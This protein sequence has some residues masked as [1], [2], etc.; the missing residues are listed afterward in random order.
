M[1]QFEDSLKTDD[2]WDHTEFVV[3]LGRTIE[4]K[5]HNLKDGEVPTLFTDVGSPTFIA[6]KGYQFIGTSGLDTNYQPHDS[7][8]ENLAI[9]WK[10]TLLTGETTDNF[11][12]GSKSATAT[13]G[14]RVSTTDN[15]VVGYLNATGPVGNLADGI[16]T[17][18]FFVAARLASDSVKAFHKD[19]LLNA[20]T[21]TF[22]D[23]PGT[24]FH[25]GGLDSA[26]VFIEGSFS[27]AEWVWVGD[28]TLLDKLP[29][30][31]NHMLMVDTTFASNTPPSGDITPPTTPG[32]NT[33]VVGATDLSFEIIPLPTDANGVDHIDVEL[34]QI[35]N[36]TIA[37]DATGFTISGLTA[38][39]SYDVRIRAFDVAGNASN[40]SNEITVSTSSGGGGPSLTITIDFET[41]P[42]QPPLKVTGPGTIAERTI[43]DPTDAGNIV[44][45]H[46][47]EITDGT[48]LNTNHSSRR[49][50]E[51]HEGI[52]G[53]PNRYTPWFSESAFRFRIYF[54]TD[55]DGT[56]GDR[57]QTFSQGHHW[58]QDPQTGGPPWVLQT[59]DL[60]GDDLHDIRLKIR[61]TDLVD[62]N[63]EVQ[64]NNVFV[65][66]R[67]VFA[68]NTWYWIVIDQTPDY[69][70]NGSGGAGI[71]KVYVSDSGF[72]TLSDLVLDHEGPVG[73]NNSSG[74]SMYPQLGMYWADTRNAAKLLE[75]WNDGVRIQHWYIDDWTHQNQHLI[76]P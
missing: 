28:T 30:I 68:E 51:Y 76:T 70:P 3:K 45:E 57:W 11:L 56:D 54:P 74:Y 53:A 60:D 65:S 25:I 7:L 9:I 71:L 21:R 41:D 39:T 69:R 62:D 34:D 1:V 48:T 23:Y 10:G 14:I 17:T 61:Y 43:T 2:I 8:D 42:G 27:I 59:Q 16:D 13:T 44:S 36:Q 19:T 52:S 22:V 75:L 26:G 5:V 6:N 72:P 35:Q 55:H 47:M 15:N 29:E 46:F 38:S 20:R 66:S 73:F 58:A 50:Y 33:T 4:S 18:S 24:D 49:E 37:G 31:S 63:V 32:I 40:W 67:D 12:V 64:N